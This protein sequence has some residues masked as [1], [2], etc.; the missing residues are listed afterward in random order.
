MAL[1]PGETQIGDVLICVNQYSG[2]RLTLGKK[3]ICL[4]LVIRKGYTYSPGPYI[5][6]EDDTGV[7]DHDA[8]FM[9]DCFDKLA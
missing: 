1:K 6:I 4:G 3:Y 2:H 5:V 9:L 7:V 8:G